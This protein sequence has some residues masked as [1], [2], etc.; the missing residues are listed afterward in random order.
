MANMDIV[1]IVD[2]HLSKLVAQTVM[3]SKLTK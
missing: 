1:K 3:R 2:A